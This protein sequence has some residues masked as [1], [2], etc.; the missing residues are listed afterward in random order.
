MISLKQFSALLRKEKKEELEMYLN[1]Q[2]PESC[3]I[4]HYAKFSNIK[5]TYGKGRLHTGPCDRIAARIRLGYRKLWELKY[6]RTGQA[7]PEYSSCV[8]C[9][10]SM[11]NN[12][13]HYISFCPKLKPFRPQGMRYHELCIYFC[14]AENI[15]P[16]LDEYPGFK[17]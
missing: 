15:S 11:A 9:G 3:S 5:H 10:E 17:M 13:Q 2:L 14:N 1:S 16:I 8:L 12:L 6:E 4:K 7:K